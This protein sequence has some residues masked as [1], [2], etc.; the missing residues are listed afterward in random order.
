MN[1]PNRYDSPTGLNI[2]SPRMMSPRTHR[3]HRSARSHR[4]HQNSTHDPNE[5]RDEAQLHTAEN[6]HQDNSTFNLDPDA[7]ILGA[8]GESIQEAI[9]SE[10]Q[11]NEM[12]KEKNFVGGF[13][14]G[15]KRVLKPT[16]NDNRQ[17]SDP[18]AAYTGTPYG[19]DNTYL[20]ARGP[21]DIEEQHP[22]SESS[23][24][25]S[26][27]SQFS[28][29]SE[30]MHGT[31]EFPDD[32]TTA[33]DHQSMPMPVPIPGH[34]VSP[35]LVE[36]Q[37]APDYAKMGSSASST[38]EGSLNSYVSRIA[39][40][41]QHINELPW[42]ADS[43]VTV[44][45][46]PGQSP[47]RARSRPPHRKVLSW[48]NRHAFPPGQNA[49]P[50]DLDAG[51]SPSPVLGQ[52]VQMIEAQ[53][54]VITKEPTKDAIQPLILP[55]VPVP[56][57]Q[58]ESG[59]TYFA[60]L[61]P[62]LP[63]RSDTQQSARTGRSIVYSVVNPSAPSTS[64]TTTTTSSPLTEPPRHLGIDTMTA[65]AQSITGYTPYQPVAPQ[66]GR[67]IHEPLAQVP[68]ASSVISTGDIREVPP[69][70]TRTG[71]PAQS[72]YPYPLYAPPTT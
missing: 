1:Y 10:E 35:I 21:A 38:S 17:Q 46:Y 61:I 70:H 4:L 19:A 9:R 20:P 6:L 60:E 52:V 59:P 66:Y 3:T 37:L 48:Y 30:T 62:P 18:E 49:E 13:V 22:H 36:P 54:S 63:P 53:P 8:G 11:R 41:F 14:V 5:V 65:L 12:R 68:V 31:Q 42:V 64:T 29:S 71:T 16:W 33:I 43:R 45:Y 27:E 15:L 34:Y 28:P 26:S 50:L 57:S 51:S 39:H 24:S 32:G 2:G 44:D 40:F 67:P 69:A 55:T 47:R 7:P 58:I 23:R 25:P 72:M 56:E